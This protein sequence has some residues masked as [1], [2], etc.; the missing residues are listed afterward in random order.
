MPAP[1]K[2]TPSCSLFLPL[3]E[4]ATVYTYARQKER[5][6]FLM[7]PEL[8][9][10][11]EWVDP[12]PGAPFPNEEAVDP[13]AEADLLFRFMK[14]NAVPLASMREWILITDRELA[15]I[16]EW[17]NGDPYLLSFVSRVVDFRRA[18]WGQFVLLLER[19]E[20]NARKKLHDD[21]LGRANHG[22]LRMRRREVKLAG[23]VHF[24]MGCTRG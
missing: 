18:T 9:K 12:N 4:A 14:R 23:D 7:G 21:R 16:Q 17:C 15:C 11:Y 5:L 13:T 3:K 10:Y 6:E 19:E 22:P 20:C 1:K 8:A 2:K 24:S